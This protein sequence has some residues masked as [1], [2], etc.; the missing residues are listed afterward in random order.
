[1]NLLFASVLFTSGRATQASTRATVISKT[2]RSAA[3]APIVQG[4]ATLVAL[5]RIHADRHFYS[6][7]VAG[8]LLVS[9]VVW[10]V[11]RWRPVP[12]AIARR[13]LVSEDSDD[14]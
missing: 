4:A 6:D 10:L 14:R 5:S 11:V 8:A 3:A 12:R 1:M 9:S 2:V 13:T 7:V